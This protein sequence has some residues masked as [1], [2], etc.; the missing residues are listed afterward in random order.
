MASR[1][2]YTNLQGGAEVFSPIIFFSNSFKR[3][4][5]QLVMET[6]LTSVTEVKC[7]FKYMCVCV[8]FSQLCKSAAVKRNLHHSTIHINIC[9]SAFHEYS[10]QLF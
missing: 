7:G 9:I 10:M 1:Q 6:G 5:V 3:E 4:Q 2:R 8:S